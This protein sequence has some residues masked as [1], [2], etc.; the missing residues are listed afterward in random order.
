MPAIT[1]SLQ[2]PS[3]RRGTD[4]LVHSEHV[5]WIVAQLDLGQPAIAFPVNAFH[6][7]RFIIRHEVDIGGSERAARSHCAERSETLQERERV[8]TAEHFLCSVAWKIRVHDPP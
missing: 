7:R 1:A 3:K 6:S 4:I 5:G 8:E 2:G